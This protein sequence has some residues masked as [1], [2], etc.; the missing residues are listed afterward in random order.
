MTDL[1]TKAY[2][3]LRIKEHKQEFCLAVA[4]ICVVEFQAFLIFDTLGMCSSL[5][6]AFICVVAKWMDFEFLLRY[7]SLTKK[8][9][10]FAYMATIVAFA[11]GLYTVLSP[12]VQWLAVAICV[13]SVSLPILITLIAEW[14]ILLLRFQYRKPFSG[15]F[16][17]MV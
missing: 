2:L 14:P 5:A 3:C 7:R 11:T 17:D 10:W 6:V 12:R 9:M 1:A 15:N 16:I 8:L 13:L 4:F